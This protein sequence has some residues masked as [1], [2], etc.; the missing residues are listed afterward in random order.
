MATDSKN[1]ITG[2]ISIAAGPLLLA[3][4]L[5]LV[6]PLAGS[7]FA[8]DYFLDEYAL[9]AEPEQL[10]IAHQKID[11][12]RNL[13]VVEN[14]LESRLALLENLELPAGS[15]N[16][17]DLQSEID[18]VI[19]GQ[20]LLYIFFD[21]NAEKLTPR[22]FRPADLKKQMPPAALFRKL[23]QMLAKENY[24]ANADAEQ[25]EG[26]ETVRN[27]LQI[28][29]MFKTVTTVNIRPAKVSMNLSVDYG[30]ELYF[31][32]FEFTR[33][34]AGQKGCLA[35]FRG[36][37][38][39][40]PAIF[41]T[42]RKTHPQLRLI[43]RQTNVQK[44]IAQPGNLFSGIRRYKDRIVT[45]A[46]AD[47]RFIRT[48]LHKSGMH[49]N[50]KKAEFDIPFIEYHLPATS[51]QHDF[52]RLRHYIGL[53][54]RLI[55]II[56][57]VQLMRMLTFG[58]DLNTSFKRRILASVMLVSLFPF[59]FLAIGFYLHR[60]YDSFLARQNLLLHVET[61]LTQI[62]NELEQYMEGLESSF[63]SFG[64]NIDRQ[65]FN[66]PQATAILFER[67]G[68]A[69]PVSALALH[70]PEK[71]QIVELPNRSSPA[72]QNSTVG[73]VERFM[74]RQLLSLLLEPEP[75]VNRVRQDIMLI[76]GNPIKNTS[77][78]D[79]LR[80]NGQFYYFDQTT[81][82]IWYSMYKLY[83]Q[84][85][86]GMPF[87]GILGAKFEPG[88]ILASYTAQM[89]V[90]D[91]NFVE[92]WG[93]FTI[94][95]A[96]LPTDRTGSKKTWA[97]SGHLGEPVIRKAA[98][99]ETSRTVSETD[100]Q[101]NRTYVISRYNHNIPHIAV[102]I[103]RVSLDIEGYFAAALSLLVYLCLVFYLVSQLL[104]RFFVNPVLQLARSAEQIA[105]G[106]DVWNLSLTTGDEFEK[107][108][109][110]FAGLVV[111]L[112]QRNL[113]SDYV[114]EDAISQIELSESHEMA[115][116]GENIEATIIFAALKNYTQLTAGLS[117]E[118][119][120][121]LIN[122]FIT[123]GDHLVKKHGGT[124][125]KI[126]DNTLMLVFRESEAH[127]DSHA[128]RAARTALDL[129]AAMH[130]QQF[131]IYAGI[132]SCTVISGRIGSYTG[133]LDFT[134]IGDQVNLAARLKNEALNSS[135]GI[136]ISGSTMRMLKGE[137]RVNFLRRCSLKGKARE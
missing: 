118:Q 97:G 40:W 64:E 98:R 92:S 87:M 78:G 137:G 110:A 67:I 52:Q 132:A 32:Y 6:L 129:A 94:K 61:R 54:S 4:L 126:I 42:L 15:T 133:K 85:A 47:Q 25:T 127:A 9:F 28:Q 80:T 105:R 113:L 60:Q 88:P 5:V 43:A 108:N 116:G 62:H 119:T 49:L 41:K 17:A 45:T 59:S 112:Q 26:Q 48:W 3:W 135:S 82:V 131:D 8:L 34:Q 71:S 86:P 76:A 96:F 100:D 91:G 13:L 39:A 81:S 114:S 37:D 31:T 65:L 101:G 90:A 111:G 30:G 7:L 128:L 21:A 38:L 123:S 70:R 122:R 73:M 20:G 50:Q 120:V 36:R 55:I 109:E 75:I 79:S 93:G 11:E 58:I 18:R 103:V 130:E 27:A 84:H 2:T 69:L 106:H 29:Q 53:I 89:P 117:P 74:P 16:V 12:Y 66:D 44:A 124:I 99:H 83:D 1:K 77:I 51:F 46:P 104:E 33:P 56:S 107:L 10:A 24:R 102:A 57:L 68:K 63:I 125:D 136:I 134:V 121:A 14:Y 72:N 22:S 115:P 19:T 23:I 95:Y 35:V